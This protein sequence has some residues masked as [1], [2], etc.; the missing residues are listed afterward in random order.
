ML[1]KSE[2]FNRPIKN[3]TKQKAHGHWGKANRTKLGKLN[4]DHKIQ[5][6][7]P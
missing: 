4:A 2:L 7:K 1:T 3:I 5:R 6:A